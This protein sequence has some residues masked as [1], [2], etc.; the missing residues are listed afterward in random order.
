VAL[1][2]PGTRFEDPYPREASFYFI[3]QNHR[4]R[5][6]RRRVGGPGE[7]V[8]AGASYSHRERWSISQSDAGTV[9]ETEA[10]S[11]QLAFLRCNH[12]AQIPFGAFCHGSGGVSLRRQHNTA[13]LSGTLPRK[14]SFSETP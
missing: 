14:G 5:T 6:A 13:N 10:M 3:R 1:P 12:M 9:F 2:I 4:T 7:P 11:P 8:D